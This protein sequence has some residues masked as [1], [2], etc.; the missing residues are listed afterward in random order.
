MYIHITN[1]QS[2]LPHP[3]SSSHPRIIFHNIIRRAM[4]VP[5]RTR[6]VQSLIIDQRLDLVDPFEP[7]DREPHLHVPSDVAMHQPRSRIVGVEG[8]DEI[9]CAR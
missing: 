3:S 5:R 7:L 6:A 1:H 4:R 9:S 8:E 2:N